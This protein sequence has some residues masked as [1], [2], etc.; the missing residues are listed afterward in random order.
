MSNYS[1][2]AVEV[3]SRRV[4]EKVGIV[5]LVE[6]TIEVFFAIMN[7]RDSLEKGLSKLKIIL[8]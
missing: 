4:A 2:I 3:V 5:S 7:K 1:S 8:F 6:Y